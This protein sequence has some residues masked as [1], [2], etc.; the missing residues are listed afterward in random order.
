MPFDQAKLSIIYAEDEIVFREITVPAINKAGISQENL[1]VAEDGLAA[2]EILD[3]LQA[4]AGAPLIM[5]LDVR[6]PKMDGMQCAKK[7]QELVA[8]KALKR[9]PF[10]VCCSSY[11]RQ[12]SFED[13]QGIFQITLPKPL[14]RKEV[15]MCIAKVSAWWAEEYGDGAAATPAPAAPAPAA[16]AAPT[17]PAGAAPAAGGTGG[18][19][20]SSVPLTDPGCL[21]LII[22]DDEPICRMAVQATLKLAGAREESTQEAE[23]EEEAM[24]IAQKIQAESPD[25]P[26]AIFLGNPSWLP[27]LQQLTST[28]KP[29]FIVCTSVDGEQTH[30]DFNATLPK[31]SKQAD[32]KQV[33]AQCLEWFGGK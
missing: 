29:P 14:G 21:T 33:L 27:A 4:D 22:A 10:M 30:G 23:D 9:V 13:D 19:P 11:V 5:L 18:T 24:E 12:V 25:K 32:V 7:V 16:P 17:E 28:G 31:Q 26:I 3:T 15:E 6:M 20:G 2:L 8:E 1:H